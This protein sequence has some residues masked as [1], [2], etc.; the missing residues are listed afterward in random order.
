[1]KKNTIVVFL[2]LAV[3]ALTYQNCG[4]PMESLESQSTLDTAKEENDN[5]LGTIDTGEPTTPGTEATPAPQPP[6]STPLSACNEI[7]LKTD[8]PAQLALIEPNG[9]ERHIVSWEEVF[10]VPAHNG[11]PEV[12][13]P[14][15]DS[16]GSFWPV[17]SFTL[18]GKNPNTQVSMKGKY[19]SIPFIAD[20]FESTS[21][22]HKLEWWKAVA[23]QGYSAYRPHPSNGVYITISTC[24]GDFRTTSAAAY[25]PGDQTLTTYCRRFRSESNMYFGENGACITVPGKKYYLNIVFAYPFDGLDPQETSCDPLGFEYLDGRCDT[26]ITTR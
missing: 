16:P 15:F 20:D 17:G 21:A 25:P 5:E 9:Y 6:T 2:V 23:I 19:I 7:R 12:T 8:D 10:T 3:I 24:A 4:K 18:G 11:L 22:R 14:F 26:M 1:M 13:F